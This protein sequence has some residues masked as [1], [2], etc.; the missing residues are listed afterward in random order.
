MVPSIIDVP[1]DMGRNCVRNIKRHSS[2]HIGGRGGSCRLASNRCVSSVGV[3]GRRT[4]NSRQI[5]SD[6]RQTHFGERSARPYSQPLRSCCASRVTISPLE[7]GSRVR[8]EPA[9]WWATRALMVL[10][11]AAGRPTL[12]GEGSAEKILISELIKAFRRVAK[13]G[14]GLWWND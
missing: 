10:P 2:T 7:K 13:G 5:N 6:L 4:T 1:I 12:T 14:L 9:G 11:P 3:S 8:L